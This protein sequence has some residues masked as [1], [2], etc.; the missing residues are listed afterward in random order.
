MAKPQTPRKAPPEELKKR[1]RRISARLR[2]TYPDAKTALKHDGAF[3]LLIA[4]I[5]SAQCTDEMVN[6]VTPILFAKFPDA[7]VFAAASQADVESIVHST[8][9]FRQKARGIINCSRALMERHGGELPESMEELTKLPGVGRKT[10]NLIRGCAMGQPGIIVDTHFKRLAGRMGLTRNTNPDK[11]EHDIAALLPPSH[12]TEFSNAMIW[13]GRR[14]C[15]ARKP[16]CDECPI[17]KDCEFGK[18]QTA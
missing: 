3:Q 15:P 13:H 1:A 16:K 6:K 14:I 18:E 7:R 10:A 4:T 8:G 17:V 9:F 12:W 5:L 2:K 11:I